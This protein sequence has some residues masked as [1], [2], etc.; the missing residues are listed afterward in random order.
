MLIAAS[1]AASSLLGRADS[2]AGGHISA[3]ARSSA[4]SLL[5]FALAS[6]LALPSWAAL[7]TDLVVRVLDANT[8]KLERLGVVSMAGARTPSRL[9]DCFTYSPAA[10]LRQLIRPKETVQL[11]AL[12]AKPKGT[13]VFLYRAR[14]GLFIN[15][16]LVEGGWAKTAPLKAGTAGELPSVTDQLQ[17][18]TAAQAAAKGTGAGLWVSCPAAGEDATDDL[19]DQFEPLDGSDFEYG[20]AAPR[21]ASALAGAAAL[22]NPGAPPRPP[23][24]TA[25]F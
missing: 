13:Q 23:P 15:E 7:E 11:Q 9:P 3:A 16:A 24:P 2:V 18:L 17:K 25:S 4:S 22:T 6:C 21:A 19:S 8:V 10:H 12:P 14:D 1:R 5:A 20:R